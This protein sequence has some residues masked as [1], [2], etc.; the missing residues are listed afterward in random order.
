M[1]FIFKA[2]ATIILS[3]L[4]VVFSMQLSSYIW[5][6][7]EIIPFSGT[8]IYN[9]YDSITV[10]SSYTE[11]FEKSNFHAHTCFD[12]RHKYTSDELIEAYSIQGYKHMGITDHQHINTKGVIPSYEHGYGLNNF[13]IGM[14]GADEVD[15]IDNFYMFFPKHQIQSAFSRLSS[16]SR[17]MVFNHSDRLRLMDDEGIEYVRCYDLFELSPTE[18]T[19]IWDRVLSTGYYVPLVA[20]DDAHSI[21]NRDSQFQRAF[22]MVYKN[23]SSICDALLKGHSYGVTITNVRN[24]NGHIDIPCIENI[25]LN[26]GTLSIKLDRTADSIVFI[27]QNG[28]TLKTQ[29]SSQ[30]S[31]YEIQENDSYVRMEIF[32]D[33]VRLYTNPVARI[34]KN[35]FLNT[36]PSINWFLSV[37]YWI[38]WSI[39]ILIDILLIRCLWKSSHKNDG[40][41]YY[42]RNKRSSHYENRVIGAGLKQYDWN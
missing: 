37:I 4:L 33:G 7:Q 25:G 6:F 10:D 12:T 23:D 9:P 1:R 30:S 41:N 3:A 32:F 35:G 17:I 42:S 18:V 39:I 22:T 8:S 26:D 27:G 28:K 2:F 29:I 16:K 34:Q 31:S 19:S 38:F 5:S 11:T 20:N 21:I 13:H 40:D 24:I 15:W 36:T 14:Y